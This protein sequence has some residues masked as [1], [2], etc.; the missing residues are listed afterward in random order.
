[1]RIGRIRDEYTSHK[2][3]REQF[4]LQRLQLKI[5]LACKNH[6]KS[7]YA[8]A[9]YKNTFCRFFDDFDMPILFSVIRNK[10][11]PE[12]ERLQRFQNTVERT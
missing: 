7:D 11:T 9:K 2:I 5:E 1:M 3:P 6:L 8:H 10:N 12:R 4:D